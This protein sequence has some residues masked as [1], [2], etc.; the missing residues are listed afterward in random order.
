MIGEGLSA[1]GLRPVKEL[2]ASRSHGDRLC[3][4]AGC[5]CVPCRAANSRYETER[6][7]ARKAG[8]WNGLVPADKARRHILKLSKANVGRRALSDVTGTAQSII[9][10]IRSGKK[11]QIRKRTETRILAVTPAAV[12][13]GA[14][15]PAART[16]KLIN[17]LL[18]EGFTKGEI[19]QLLGRKTR[20]LQIRKDRV[21]AKTAAAIERLYQRI[22]Q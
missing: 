13:G 11:Q 9:A 6:A 10:A 1:R 2:A 7:A 14:I 15:V 4:M 5:R 21:T 16:W 22:M 3:Y 20:N 18:S 8:D 12:S 19:A 17:R